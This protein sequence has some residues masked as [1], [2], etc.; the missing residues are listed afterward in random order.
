MRLQ[1]VRRKVW[2]QRVLHLDQLSMTRRG[3]VDGVSQ[4]HAFGGGLLLAFTALLLVVMPFTEYFFQFDRF[5]RGGQD[6]E[7]NLLLLAM[8]FSM[9]IVLSQGRRQKVESILAVLRRLSGVFVERS[10]PARGSVRVLA[11][12]RDAIA[13]SSRALEMYT[14]PIRI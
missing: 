13:V 14:L 3:S 7:F 10:Q 1:V 5:L 4:A 2:F 6:C 9:V 11:M 8:F 12:T